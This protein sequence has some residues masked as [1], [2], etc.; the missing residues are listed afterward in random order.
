MDCNGTVDAAD[1]LVVLRYVAGAGLREVFVAA[2]LLLVIGIAVLMGLGAIFGA[3]NTMYSAVAN[4]TSSFELDL[5]PAQFGQV[6]YSI[7]EALQLV[8]S[9]PKSGYLYLFH[10]SP[11]GELSLLFPTPGDDNRIAAGADFRL[12]REGA[13]QVPGPLGNHI[14]KAILTEQPLLITGLN[15]EPQR[16]V[17]TRRWQPRSLRLIDEVIKPGFAEAA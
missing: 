16:D 14:L 2:S 12:P 11:V 9:S 3:V 7:G 17:Q 6:Q 4:R 13:A 5:R 15:H 10:L 1:S 8:A